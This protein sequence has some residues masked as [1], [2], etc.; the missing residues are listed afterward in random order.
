MDFKNGDHALDCGVLAFGFALIDKDKNRV[1]RIWQIRAHENNLPTL[2]DIQE[3]V[4]DATAEL[5]STPT[6]IEC[7]V[8]TL[9]PNRMEGAGSIEHLKRSIPEYILGSW[10]SQTAFMV[11]ANGVNM[12]E[13]GDL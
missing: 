6:I 1:G 5:G 12:S 13:I 8:R 3:M 11:S 2:N 10:D 7:Y 4:A 9:G